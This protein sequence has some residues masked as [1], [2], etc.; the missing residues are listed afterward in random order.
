MIL[1]N[2]FSFISHVDILQYTYRNTKILI[3]AEYESFQQI[4]EEILETHE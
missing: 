4:E 3:S 2:I 1:T